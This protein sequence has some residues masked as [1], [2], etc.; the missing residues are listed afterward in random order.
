MCSKIVQFSCTEITHYIFA[1]VS[2]C[3]RLS[4]YLCLCVFVRVL[5]RFSRVR[6]FV[7]PWTAARQA[8]LS[9]GFSRQ[10]YCSRLPFPI[11]GDLLDSGVEPAS[12]LAGG[13]FTTSTTCVA[14]LYPSP[15][16]LSCPAASVTFPCLSGLWP[17]PLQ[18]LPA[19]SRCLDP[20]RMNSLDCDGL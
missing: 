18:P 12:V 9:M 1:L 7:T 19:I 16:S 14:S 2:V 17:P 6:L 10:E 4:V 8:P 20:C 13:F 15:P 3:L 11:P 5:S